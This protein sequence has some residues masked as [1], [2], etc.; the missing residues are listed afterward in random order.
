MVPACAAKLP[1]PIANAIVAHNLTTLRF[2]FLISA[3]T[4]L[5]VMVRFRGFLSVSSKRRNVCFHRDRIQ[6][7][8]G[9]PPEQ[10]SKRSQAPE[11]WF[12]VNPAASIRETQKQPGATGSRIV[13]A[14]SFSN[15][16]PS[17]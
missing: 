16:R 15:R 14:H 11:E 17:S 4:S 6:H 3:S 9:F 12:G 2:S 7:G 10:G 1:S 13:C 5:F 8:D